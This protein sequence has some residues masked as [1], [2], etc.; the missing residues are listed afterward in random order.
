LLSEKTIAER[1]SE[2]AEAISADF[3]G[4]ELTVV[5]VLKGSVFFAAD[6]TR[7]L[8]VPCRLAFI[9]AKSYEGTR[10]GD[11]VQLTVEPELSLHGKHVLVVE[12]ILDTGRTLAAILERLRAD[13]PATLTVCTLLDKPARRENGVSP[14][15]VGFE[16]DDHFVVGYGLDH[17]EKYRHLPGVYI[18]EED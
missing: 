6:L 15:Y 8:R 11:C 14:D 5:L 17:E 4:R 2:L 1:V 13:G 18:L 3:A 9:R 12:D 7:R 16:V 10:P